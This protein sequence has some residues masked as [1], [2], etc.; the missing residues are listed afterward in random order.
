MRRCD[1]HETPHAP[2]RRAPP[3]TARCTHAQRIDVAA[4]AVFIYVTGWRI[5]E[6]RNL[7][8]ADVNLAEGVVRIEDGETK[9]TTAK[10]FPFDAHPDLRGLIEAQ[11]G[12]VLDIQRR[13]G[14]MFPWVFPRLNGRK[15]GSFRKVWD[16]AC[17]AAEIPGRLPYDM[18]RSAIRSMDRAGVPRVVAMQLTGL[19][20]ES[21]FRRY[22]I[23]AEEELRTAVKKLG[24]S[25]GGEQKNG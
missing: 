21:I 12:L 23:L 3:R 19:K 15:L 5:G 2:A 8:W 6:V 4:V 7:K 10:T 13:H 22:R 1:A 25:R 24:S 18:K 20:T 9:N 16:R 14:A 11:Q 17:R